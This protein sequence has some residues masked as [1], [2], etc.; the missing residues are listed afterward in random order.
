MA[1]LARWT[2]TLRGLLTA[3]RNGVGRRGE[4]LASVLLCACLAACGLGGGGGVTPIRTPFNKGVYHY[5][6]S[7]WDAAI[8]E[9]RL[10][11][12][13]DEDDYR[14]RFNLAMA[15]EA[16]ARAMEGAAAGDGQ[17]I[18]ELKAEAEREYNALANRRP[19]NARVA[20]NLAALEYESGRE[21]EA[22]ARL[23]RVIEDH[24]DAVPVL[25]ALGAHYFREVEEA[26]SHSE[27]QE[28]L[29]EAFVLLERAV[30]EAPANVAANMLLGEIHVQ[31]REPELAREAFRRALERD[32]SDIG[33]L[34][35][36][37][38]LESGQGEHAEAVIW[39]QRVVYVDPNHVDA[40]LA[41]STAF[42]AM[43][44]SWSALFH[45]WQA[46]QLD[47]GLEVRRQPEEYRT[48]LIHL[49]EQVSEGERNAG[50]E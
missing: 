42:E 13:E 15:L 7:R 6:A 35:A 31:R 22:K 2:R 18:E 37:A 23:R 19:E 41:L 38:R 17:R 27:A 14:A 24:P 26:A 48:Q 9:F 45:L 21:A 10:A 16:K 36:L 3:S 8:A 46:R 43:E 49:L 29:G 4:L 44:D 33:T 11:V 28:K 50:G 20:V 47:H 25:T 40:H 12:D 1:K 5:S 34:L 32:P 30:D 39:A